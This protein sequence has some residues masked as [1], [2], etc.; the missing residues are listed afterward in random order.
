MPLAPLPGEKWRY[1]NSFQ[2]SMPDHIKS[3]DK[4]FRSSDRKN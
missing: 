4:T 1:I 2:L 3:Y